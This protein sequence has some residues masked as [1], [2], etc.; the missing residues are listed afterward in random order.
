[1]PFF[2]LFYPYFFLQL[3]AIT[4][5]VDKDFAFYV[6]SIL[7]AASVFGRWI[8]GLLA[9]YVG[10]L[11][12]GTLTALGTGCV[13]FTM[14]AVHDKTSTIIFAVFFGLFSGSLI[15]STPAMAARHAKDHS[16]IGVRMGLFF[17]VGGVIGLVATPIAGALLTDQ[18]H[19]SRPTLFAG[20][21]TCIGGVCCGIARMFFA[22]QE[23]TWKV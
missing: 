18:Y 3:N 15:G 7:N 22:K 8:P 13:I 11:N 17:A 21:A 12:I 16:D 14:I 5:H 1:L 2:G 20:I 6:V 19:W 9:P 10:I 23:K 4:H